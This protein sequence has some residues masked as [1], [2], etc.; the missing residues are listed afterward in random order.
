M[1][2]VEGYVRVL[3]FGPIAEAI[4]SRTSKLEWHHG[5][6]IE[7][8]VHALDMQHWIGQGLTVALNGE[9]CPLDI[10]PQKGDEVALLPPVSG[11]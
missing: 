9:R 4:G 6:S 8:I 11:G 2:E 10:H 3:A 7:D 5:M 1:T